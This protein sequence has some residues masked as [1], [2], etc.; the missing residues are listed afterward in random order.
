MT[1]SSHEYNLTNAIKTCKNLCSIECFDDN[2]HRNIIPQIADFFTNLT[3]LSLFIHYDLSNCDELLSKIFHNNRKLKLIKL[4]NFRSLTGKC[5]LHLNEA[6]I[7][8]IALDEP[9]N[10]QKEYLIKSWSIFKNLHILELK[11]FDMCLHDSLE[12]AQV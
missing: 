12:N 11:R 8:H 4:T 9:I 7:E 3:E 10:I 5:F 6:A 2:P 1:E